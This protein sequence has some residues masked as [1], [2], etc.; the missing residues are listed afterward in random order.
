VKQIIKQVPEDERDN[1]QKVKQPAWTEP[2]LATLTKNRFSDESWLYERK[3]DGIRCLA[4][5][6]DENIRLMSRNKQN[7]NNTYPELVDALAAQT[8]VDLIVDGEVV[9]F[10]GKV[11]SFSRL[12][13]RMKIKDPAKATKSGI[14]AYFYVFDILHLDGFD[15]TDLGLETRKRLLKSTL[16]SRSRLRLLGHR[17][18]EGE[19]YFRQACNRGWEG[20]IAKQA[21]STY[22]HG[23]SKRWLKFK[24]VNRQELVIAGYTEPK[25]ERTGFGALLVGY[26]AGQS[27]TYAG[28]V[29]TGYDEDTLE[30]LGRRL[31]SMER[32]TPPLEDARLPSKGV[33]WVTPRLVGQFGFTEWTSDGKLRH[34]RFL[35]L[36]PDK[37]PEDVVREN[38]ERDK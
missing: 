33:H 19:A 3:L 31:R 34:P 17:R 30:R 6:E 2:M 8:S 23:R 4:F 15:L 5:K 20:I 22:V 24:C 14:A 25:G 36:R 13:Q 7:L 28:K 10:E 27:L 9:A 38:S 1:V 21:A 35:G 11:T 37:D 29:G 18:K 32:K 16:S 26:Y 12:Q